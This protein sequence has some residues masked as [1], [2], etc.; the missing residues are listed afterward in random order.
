VHH[1]GR[2]RHDG[3]QSIKA[4][5][6][7]GFSGRNIEPEASVVKSAGTYPAD[8]GLDGVEDRQQ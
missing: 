6:A 3:E 4:G 2:A 8:M 1:D 5:Y 7:E